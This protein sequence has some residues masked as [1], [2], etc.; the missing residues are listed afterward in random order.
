MWIDS[1][2]RA[3]HAVKTWHKTA[4]LH[5]SSTNPALLCTSEPSH[6]VGVAAL[7]WRVCS[8]WKI[9][10][11]FWCSKNIGCH[12]VRLAGRRN[13]FCTSKEI[14][15]PSS[16]GLQYPAAQEKGNKRW[17]SVWEPIWCPPPHS[18]LYATK[19]TTLIWIY[20]RQ[21][22]DHGISTFQQKS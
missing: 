12:S 3:T 6:A 8:F 15:R 20:F 22:Q 5:S 16:R 11:F 13:F 10:W 19:L 7:T 9:L 18:P 4:A 21:I 17:M 14:T 1:V 2:L